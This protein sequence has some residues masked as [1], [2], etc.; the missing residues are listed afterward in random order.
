[1]EK[2]KSRVVNIK[3]R[4]ANIPRKLK[5][6]N[7]EV[8]EVKFTKQARKPVHNFLKYWRITRYW[9]KRKYNI[10]QEELEVLLFLYDEEVFTRT[11]FSEF[12][13]L[14]SYDN[15]RF[16][17]LQ[18]KGLIVVWRE[19][20]GFRNK[21]LFTLSMQAKRMCA[22]VYKKLIQEEKFPENRQNNP[23][24]KGNDYNDRMYRKMIKMMNKKFE[25]KQNPDQE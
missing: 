20:D 13:A 12:N 10:S 17:K 9:V 1:M 24:F 25:E 5:T 2:K 22:E 11:T 21:K 3:V 16:Q 4:V 6:E 8:K 7:G 14:L 15:T 18:D 23:I 19:N